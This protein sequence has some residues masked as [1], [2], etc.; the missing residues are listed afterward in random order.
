MGLHDF[1]EKFVQAGIAVLAFDYRYYGGSGG[2]PRHKIRWAALH[3]GDEPGS[4]RTHGQ[5][6]R[7]NETQED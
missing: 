6:R 3:R 1:A 7:Q 2:F 4:V 5:Q